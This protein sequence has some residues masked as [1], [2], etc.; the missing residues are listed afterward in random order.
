MNAAIPIA[1]TEVNRTLT[2]VVRGIRIVRPAIH[3]LILDEKCVELSFGGK[4]PGTWGWCK[5]SEVYDAVNG[6]LKLHPGAQFLANQT[7][8]FTHYGLLGRI[9]EKR[10]LITWVV[11]ERIRSWSNELPNDLQISLGVFVPAGWVEEILDMAKFGITFVEAIFRE[12]GLLVAGKPYFVPR[13]I[14]YRADGKKF[15]IFSSHHG[16]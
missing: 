6:G 15:E 16:T 13:L 2:N 4:D 14:G 7:Q 1:E 5:L 11:G 10:P 3:E 12:T 9:V 8:V